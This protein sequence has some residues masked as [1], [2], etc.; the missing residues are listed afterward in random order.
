MFKLVMNEMQIKFLEINFI[1][2]CKG[3]CTASSLW[4]CLIYYPVSKNC[5]RFMMERCKVAMGKE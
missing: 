4:V 5:H 2:K 3:C 1:L